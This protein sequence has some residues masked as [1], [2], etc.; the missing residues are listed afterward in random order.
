[1]ISGSF[2]LL[3]KVMGGCQVLDSMLTSGERLGQTE[4][5]AGG[6]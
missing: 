6:L 4:Y 3:S 5:P 2:I 1:M